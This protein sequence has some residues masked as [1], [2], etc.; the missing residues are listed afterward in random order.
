MQTF[1]FWLSKTFNMNVFQ[2][3]SKQSKHL[4]IEE[5]FSQACE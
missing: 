5:K 3:Q 1:L 2:V 4:Y